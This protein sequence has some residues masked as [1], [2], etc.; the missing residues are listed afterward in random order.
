MQESLLMG[1]ERPRMKEV[2]AELEGLRGTKTKHKW[3]EQYPEPQEAE[4]LL[5]VEI[6]SA[7]GDTNAI[8]Y[9]SIMNVTR[10]HIEDGR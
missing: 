2:A 6:L 10:L 7:Q 5:G 3:S 8:G 1:E 9:D 4:H